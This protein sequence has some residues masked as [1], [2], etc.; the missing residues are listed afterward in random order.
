MPAQTQRR[1]ALGYQGVR[2]N[3]RTAWLRCQ[4]QR[5]V[6]PL[7]VSAQRL[8]AARPESSPQR[9][10][11]ASTLGRRGNACGCAGPAWRTRF[12]G[13][14]QSTARGVQRENSACRGRRSWPGPPR[15]S[16]D[17]GRFDCRCVLP[18]DGALD[19]GRASGCGGGAAYSSGHG[20][21]SQCKTADLAVRNRPSPRA[22]A[23]GG[24]LPASGAIGAAVPAITA[25]PRRVVTSPVRV[26]VSE[27]GV[28]GRPR[29]PNVRRR[30]PT[31]RPRRG[32]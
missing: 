22:G 4:V 26:F 32:G 10:G 25:L 13:F 18:F 19:R 29:C 5:E 27:W 7:R 15:F 6:S 12:R 31:R 17:H 2:G 16:P 21:H 24:G 30:R 1:P 20:G 28:A 23:G 14:L 8:R 9:A 3:G 11:V